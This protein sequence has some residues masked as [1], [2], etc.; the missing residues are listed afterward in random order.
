MVTLADVREALSA[1]SV[2]ESSGDLAAVELTDVVSDSRQA[3]PGALFC[4]VVGARHDGHDHAAA[5]V[6]AGAAALLCERRLELDV[7]QVVVD[8][9]RRA[10]AVAAATV[11]GRPGDELTLIG[12][13][14]TNGKTTTVSMLDAV[15][16]SAGRAAAVIG[17]LTGERT[18]PESTDLQRQLRALRDRGVDTVAMEVS[19]HAL[20][21][22]R[23][24]A[25]TFDVAV[26][27]MLG[28]DH[29]DYHG[30]REA[31]FAAKAQLFEPGR[32][33]AAVL[34][35]DDLHGRLLS[36][37]AEVPVVAVSLQ[38]AGPLE[39]GPSGSTVRWR[40]HPLRVPI[41]GPHNVTNALLA[42]EAARRIGIDE[43]DVVRGLAS[44]PDV[45]G[46]FERFGAP[47]AAEVV[48]DYAHTPDALE[49]VLTASRAM[50]ARGGRV[51][52]VFGCGGERDRGK[53]P[54]MGEVACR[55]A[56]EVIL[57]D[58]NPRGDDPDAIIEDIRKG[59]DRPVQVVRD[60][61]TAIRRGVEAAGPGDLVLVAGK[62]HEQGQVVGSTVR[63]FDDRSVVR[64]VLGLAAI[65]GETS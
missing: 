37:A 38:A 49:T 57:T 53:R 20:D 2:R 17:T 32:C 39:L 30:T 14:G 65:D 10:M 31:Y 12:V 43:A 63:P 5:A 8:D 52:V 59:C 60:R 61:E 1:R 27:T 26:F 28:V 25:L 44:M 4:C 3:G 46:R 50:V 40:G 21:Q 34:N 51:V 42:A 24:D 22:H 18:T 62:G 47:G 6:A 36:D 16:R 54:L 45:P 55:L 64:A 58:D 56:D 33:D 48:V 11:H 13:T 7:A 29:L 9:V 23:V 19:S 41:A 15:L 35:V